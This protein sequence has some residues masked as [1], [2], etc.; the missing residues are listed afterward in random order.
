LITSKGKPD[1]KLQKA[2]HASWCESPDKR[3]Y[4]AYLCGRPLPGTMCCVLGRETGIAE[5]EWDEDWP[6]VKG[7]NGGRQNVPPESFGA[8]AETA[9]VFSKNCRYTFNS[10]S[11]HGDFK[12][13][14]EPADP[15]RYSLT[16]RPGYLRL[17]GG[18]SPV[19]PYGQTLLAR[20]QQDFSFTA[21]TCL[22]FTPENFQEMAG[23]CWRYDDRNQYLLALTWDE[24][25]GRVL[26]V[27]SMK[28]GIFSRE[29]GPAIPE[30]S[31]Y[32]KLDVDKHWGKFL[33]SQDGK[34]YTDI[35]KALDSSV[36]SDDYDTLGFTGAFIG[37]FCVDTARYEVAAD[38]SFFNYC[39]NQ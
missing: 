7:A 28:A 29:E 3:W 31:L 34:N 23:L 30:G 36:L 5:M 24:N 22:E 17:R 39:I 4:L 26:S 18:Q 27:L 16:S 15:S 38:F 1:L 25:R 2:G 20:R 11:I 6:Y 37:L 33:Y 19:S 8:P 14:R 10:T 21:E 12:T 9:E 32:M 13:L 35:G